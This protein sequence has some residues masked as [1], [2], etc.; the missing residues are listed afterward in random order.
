[1]FF[2]MASAF[3]PGDALATGSDV[4]IA[5]P[6]ARTFCPEE[7]RVCESMAQIS[8]CDHMLAWYRRA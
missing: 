3:A 8:K 4:R 1:V 5:A 6:P 7:K 2:Q